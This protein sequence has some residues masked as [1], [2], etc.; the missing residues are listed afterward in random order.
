[1][2]HW[3]MLESLCLLGQPREE[4]TLTGQALHALGS[5]NYVWL[6]AGVQHMRVLRM[7]HGFT[8]VSPPPFALAGGF[9]L[10]FVF[11]GFVF[12]FLCFFPG[13][14]SAKVFLVVFSSRVLDDR[15]CFTA[16]SARQKKTLPGCASPWLAIGTSWNVTLSLSSSFTTPS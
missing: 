11:V 1:M 3:L 2:A 10:V 9:L 8:L 5:W 4:R 7:S 16:R 13:F 12:G 15:Q 14:A 6:L